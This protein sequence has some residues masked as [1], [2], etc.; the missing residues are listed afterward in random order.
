M[1]R[2]ENMTTPKEHSNFPKTNPRDMDICYLPNQE[3]KIAV[4]RNL[5][6]LQKKTQ[7]DKQNQEDN[8]QTK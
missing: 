6:K 2:Q 3:S 7:K 5:S 4:L 1:K 8:T